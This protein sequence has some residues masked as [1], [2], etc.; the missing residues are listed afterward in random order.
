MCP[1]SHIIKLSQLPR[2]GGKKSKSKRETIKAGKVK[3]K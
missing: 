3:V 2:T 1:C